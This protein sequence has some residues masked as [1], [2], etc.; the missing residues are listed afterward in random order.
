MIQIE[1]TNHLYD[2]LVGVFE[3]GFLLR[4]C[5]ADPIPNPLPLLRIGTI[6]D[7][8]RATSGKDCPGQSSMQ[9][10]SEKPIATPRR[11]TDENKYANNNLGQ[12]PDYA[13]T[14]LNYNINITAPQMEEN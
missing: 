12:N 4:D 1:F 8:R 11:A 10:L 3:Q 14:E 9:N 2:D 7:L 6:R 5:V 13:L